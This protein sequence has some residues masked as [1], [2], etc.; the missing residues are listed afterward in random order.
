MAARM[1]HAVGVPLAQPQ[2]A[3]CG[4]AAV[5]EAVRLAEGMSR[6]NARD[7]VRDRISDVPE[8]RAHGR[9]Y[10]FSVRG[11]GHRLQAT[12]CV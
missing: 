8:E 2:A 1:Q 9:L 11:K 7:L 3:A 5:P 4:F 6:Q 10:L 12:V